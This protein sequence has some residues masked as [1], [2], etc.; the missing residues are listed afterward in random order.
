MASSDKFITI[1]V[2]P[3]RKNKAFKLV[4]SSGHLKLVAALSAI[5]LIVISGVFV[6]YVG[7]LSQSIENKRLRAQNGEL[8]SQ[9]EVV[10]S[11]MGTIETTLERLKALTT[12]LK[13][14][15]AVNDPDRGLNLAMGPQSREDMMEEVGENPGSTDDRM[16]SSL[17]DEPVFKT[18]SLPDLTANILAEEQDR[19]Y[20]KLSIRLERVVKQSQLR[21]VGMVEMMDFLKDREDILAST[22]FGKP[23]S[24]WITSGFGIRV[25]PTSGKP[26]MHEGL[27]IA[28]AP[29]SPVYAPADG[30]VKFAGYDPG[31]G[32]VIMIEHGYGVETRYGHNSQLKVVAGQ[33]IK[34]GE[35]IS[36]VG[37]TGRSTGPHLHYE[38]LHNGAPINPENYILE[39]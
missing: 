31:Y 39:Q 12:K 27:D 9:F 29:G 35:L 11:K 4:I 32:K 2:I 21:E 15:T 37:S 17:S 8:R 25:S 28:A 23:T 6:D 36:Q 1:M 3:D 7:L 34:R 19:D 26:H 24:G 30:V 13:L 22:P 18:K 16:P 10:Q 38:V 20:A 33:H 5:V 14:I